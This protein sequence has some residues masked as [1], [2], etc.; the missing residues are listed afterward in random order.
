MHQ[1]LTKWFCDNCGEVIENVDVGHV[2]WKRDQDLR[3]YDFKIIHRKCDESNQFPCWDSLKDFL[4]P[5]GL[6][7]LLSF[8][9]LGPFLSRPGVSS[10]LG[11]ANNDQFVDLVRRVQLPY[12][13]EARQYFLREGMT[14]RMA[15]ENEMS[16]YRVES[17][18]ELI[19]ESESDAE[20]D[21]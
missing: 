5:D 12:Y 9:S 16:P 8:L 11:L 6:S 2:V 14:D 15:G 10:T 3:E 19:A 21:N 13:E 1:P 4:G 7:H 20:L 18:R 17:L